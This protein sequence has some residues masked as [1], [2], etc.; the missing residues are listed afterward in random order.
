MLLAGLRDMYDSHRAFQ[1]IDSAIRVLLSGLPAALIVWGALRCEPLLSNNVARFCAY[2][3]DASY[4]IYL[5]HLL[6]LY[7][8]RQHVQVAPWPAL[9]FVEAI[10]LCACIGLASYELIER[11]IMQIARRPKRSGLPSNRSEFIAAAD[12]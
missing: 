7:V 5:S 2:L 8:L 6:V 10:V 3:G 12:P 1:P 11:P 9:L 4:S